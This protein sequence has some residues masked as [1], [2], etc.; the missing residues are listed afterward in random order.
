MLDRIKNTISSPEFKTTVKEAAREVVT[1]LVVA[2]A[3]KATVYIVVKGSQALIS[4]ISSKDE[5]PA[6]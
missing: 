1:T 2:I 4:E 3:V 6:E 5:A